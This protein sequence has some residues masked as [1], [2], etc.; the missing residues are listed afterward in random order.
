MERDLDE[1]RVV[2]VKRRKPR[3]IYIVEESSEDETLNDK[4]LKAKLENKVSH[5]KLSFQD[6]SGN[7]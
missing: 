7:L 4:Q 2:V 1:N 6:G 3:K 5:H